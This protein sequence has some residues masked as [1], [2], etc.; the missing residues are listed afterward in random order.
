MGTLSDVSSPVA[1]LRSM[2]VA[3]R[4]D[5]L[6]SVDLMR[7]VVMVIMA[8]DHVRDFWYRYAFV[9]PTDIN[10]T[11]PDLFFT[12]W[13]THYCAPTFIFLAGTGAF[14]SRSRGK[15]KVQL[16]WFLFSRGLWLAFYELVI[17]RIAWGFS[18]DYHMHTPG[19]FWAIGMSMVVLSVLVYLPTMFVTV[20]GLGMILIHN[21][22]DG[23]TAAQVGLPEQL[24]TVLHNN[25]D[26]VYWHLAD[27]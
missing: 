15:S 14:L 7:G 4:P 10:I 8:L 18:F 22:Y 20:F 23:W 17:N 24:W 11:T 1:P 6:D 3:T 2:S 16:S 25:V 12:R 5:R 13:I 26:T 19:V 9:D 21:S 27:G